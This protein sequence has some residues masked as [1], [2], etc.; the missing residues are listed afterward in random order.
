MGRRPVDSKELLTAL[1]FCGLCTYATLDSF[2]TDS[3]PGFWR[4]GFFRVYRADEPVSFWI[5]RSLVMAGAVIGIW[6][7]VFLLTGDRDRPE[8]PD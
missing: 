1:L 6:D 4:D 3:V 8:D 7:I 2:V 5:Y